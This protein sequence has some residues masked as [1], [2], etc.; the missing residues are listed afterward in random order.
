[1]RLKSYFLLAPP[2]IT[3]ALLAAEIQFSSSVIVC[4]FSF[5]G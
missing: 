2:A 5:P 3:M 1:M 4:V